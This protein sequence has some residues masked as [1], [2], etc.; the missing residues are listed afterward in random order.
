MEIPKG[1][2]LRNFQIGLEKQL[3]V[4][5]VNLITC[6]LEKNRQIQASI[7]LLEMILRQER[8][9]SILVKQSPLKTELKL[10]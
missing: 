8:W 4:H 6:L 2:A 3:R 7:F 9:L 10:I 5:E 1:F